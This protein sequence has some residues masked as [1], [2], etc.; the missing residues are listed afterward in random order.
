MSATFI[1][2]HFSLDFSMIKLLPSHKQLATFVLEFTFCNKGISW[3]QQEYILQWL[4]VSQEIS[5]NRF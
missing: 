5:Y 2:V 4:K 1:Q 3:F